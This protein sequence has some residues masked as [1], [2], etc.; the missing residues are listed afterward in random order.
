MYVSRLCLVTLR[1]PKKLFS[2]VSHTLSWMTNL[3]PSPNLPRHRQRQKSAAR[4]LSRRARRRH[5]EG[6]AMLSQVSQMPD[7]TEED[8]PFIR[9]EKGVEGG[10]GDP[11]A[12]KLL[13]ALLKKNEAEAA[14]VAIAIKLD[15]LSVQSSPSWTVRL[16]RERA[17]C[18][19]TAV[20]GNRKLPCT[21]MQTPEWRRI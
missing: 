3:E 14:K 15:L 12:N 20:S 2:S 8:N 17:K 18:A 5:L 11:T 13:R 1:P 16:I 4:G 19:G 10:I 21:T 6:A 7:F 9:W